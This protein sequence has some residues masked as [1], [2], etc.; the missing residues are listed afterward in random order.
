L[1]KTEELLEDILEE[2]RGIR[3]GLVEIR[4]VLPLVRPLNDADDH[5]RTLESVADALDGLEELGDRITGGIGRIGG[6][7][8]E[9]ISSKLTMIEINTTPD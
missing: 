5:Q 8:L 9:D 2:L 1:S 3:T 6:A 4:E 7:S